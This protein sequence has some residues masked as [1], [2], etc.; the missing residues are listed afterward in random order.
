MTWLFV[1]NAVANALALCEGLETIR[2]L[3]LAMYATLAL[4]ATA[5]VLLW[6]GSRAEAHTKANSCEEVGQAA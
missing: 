5:C 2:D 4:W 1:G 6:Q 3:G